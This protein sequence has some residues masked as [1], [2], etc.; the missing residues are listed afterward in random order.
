M[1]LTLSNLKPAKGSNKRK[2]RIG[3]GNASGRG[4]YSGRGL[5]GQRS[6]S[7][8]KGGLKVMGMKARLQKVPKL[9]GF[10]SPH[11]K[12]EVVNLADLEKYFA[13]G[14]QVTIKSLKNLSIHEISSSF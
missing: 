4:T 3:R 14:G 9:R 1:A 8:G 12:A 10:K 11:P 2:R 7:G 13:D 6:R 5:K